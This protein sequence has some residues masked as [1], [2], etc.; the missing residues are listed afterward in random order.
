MVQTLS[1]ERLPI[2]ISGNSIWSPT[3]QLVKSRAP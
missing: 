1:S 2:P 3:R